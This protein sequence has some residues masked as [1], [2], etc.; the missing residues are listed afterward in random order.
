MRARPNPHFSFLCIVL[1]LLCCHRVEIK[2][3]LGLSRT[4]TLC[5]IKNL[6]TFCQGL[7]SQPWSWEPQLSVSS[8]PLPPAS[9]A[10]LVLSQELSAQAEGDLTK[11][12]NY[13]NTSSWAHCQLDTG[14]T[15]M[16]NSPS[17]PGDSPLG[18]ILTNWKQFQLG[19]L[20]P[21]NSIWGST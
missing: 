18:Y 16:G 6:K 11:S 20:C 3:R 1:H 15:T 9:L 7:N 10:H 12:Y 17:I 19:G 13:V 21:R 4:W 8:R 14:F 2:F 5:E